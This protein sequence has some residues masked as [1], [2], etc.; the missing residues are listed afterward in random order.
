MSAMGAQLPFSEQVT[1]C[2]RRKETAM[3]KALTVIILV[4][5]CGGVSAC[6]RHHWHRLAS[7]EGRPVSS[8]S[9]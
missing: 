4:A 1:I 8:A 2:S 6:G 5:V 3:R 9:G 7:A